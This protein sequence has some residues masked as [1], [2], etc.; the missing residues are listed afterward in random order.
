MDVRI[1]YVDPTHKYYLDGIELPISITG[2]IHDLFPQFDASATINKFFDNWSADKNSK[3]HALISYLRIVRG[4]SD[5]A[6]KIEIAALWASSGTAASEAGTVM[7]AEIEAYENDGLVP[8]DKTKE[9]AQFEEWKRRQDVS[10]WTI[11]RTEWS[12]YNEEAQVAGQIDALYKDAKD[13]YIMCDWKRCDP[14]PRRAGGAMELLGPDMDC[15]GNEMGF[16]PCAHLPNTKFG[17][18]CV[19]QNLYSGILSTLYGITVKRMYLVQMHPKLNRAHMVQ[20]PYMPEMAA[21]IFANRIATLA[22][23]P[24]PFKRTRTDDGP[25]KSPPDSTQTSYR[26]RGVPCTSSSEATHTGDP[27]EEAACTVS[28]QGCPPRGSCPG[29]C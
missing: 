22:L 7:H 21:N 13:E 18:Y 26:S 25:V 15:F 4:L 10:G 11:F 1:R 24:P 5:A 17:H 12:V 29:S 20:V 8:S 23:S 3:Y 2:V 19:Q 6:V 14:T 27:R 28:P 9:Y 16:G